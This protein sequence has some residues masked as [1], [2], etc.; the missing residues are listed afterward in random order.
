MPVEQLGELVPTGGGDP[1][2]LRRSPLVI[3]R[4]PKCDIVLAFDNVSGKHC[5][6]ELRDGYWHVEDLGSSNGIRVD[7]QRCM[8]SPLPPGTTLRVAKHEYRIVYTPAGDRP[9]PEVLGG[10]KFGGSLMQLAG[11]EKPERRPEKGG[12]PATLATSRPA[13]SD[14]DDEED[15]ALRFLLDDDDD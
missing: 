13:P 1:I 9:V 6:L 8:E 11:L 3:G 5:R 15:E 14:D 12:K 7:G 2:P 10:S 4:R